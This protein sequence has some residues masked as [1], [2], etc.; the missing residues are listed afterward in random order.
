MP[1]NLNILNMKKTYL[2]LL[3]LCGLCTTV[4]A[5]D[6]MEPLPDATYVSVISIPGTHDTATN[7]DMSL[8]SFSQT[9]D[10]DIATQWSPR[11]PRF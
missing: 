9:Q 7:K 6:W 5:D 3:A 10:I 2:T 4:S 8:A 11:Y 1:A